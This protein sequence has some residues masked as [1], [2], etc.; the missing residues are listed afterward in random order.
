MLD[1]VINS[2]IG[3]VSGILW[4]A[5]SAFMIW[6]IIE[7]ATKEPREGHE[8]LVWVIITVFVPYLGALVYYLIRRPERIR[9]FGH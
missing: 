9:A 7:A 5:F 8:R 4:L 2:T 1:F 6:M 3:L